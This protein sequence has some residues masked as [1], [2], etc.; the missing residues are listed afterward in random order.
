MVTPDRASITLPA[1]SSVLSGAIL[2]TSSVVRAEYRR[3]ADG[4]HSHRGH[5]TGALCR[6]GD[7]R[8]PEP[9]AWAAP[10][11]SRVHRG[12]GVYP[13]AGGEGVRRRMP[14]RGRLLHRR[15]AA[16]GAIP[17]C[18][19]RFVRGVSHLAG[20]GHDR[21]RRAGRGVSHRRRRQPRPAQGSGPR[22]RGNHHAGGLRAVETVQPQVHHHHAGEL[23]RDRGR[24]C[25]VGGAGVSRSAGART[26]GQAVGRDLPCLSR[27]SAGPAGSVAAPHRRPGGA[28]RVPERARLHGATLHRSRHRPHRGASGRARLEG[29]HRPQRVGHAIRAQRPHRRGVHDAAQPAGRRHGGHHQ[30]AELRRPADRETSA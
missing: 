5:E 3:C 23:V 28:T 2:S 1:M 8:G 16:A 25:A 10:G 22:A 29:R 6:L 18:A 24:G 27:G 11:H 7:R 26:G 19:G 20:Q 4:L 30:A 13:G 21:A 15:R 14:L 17:A 12:G 9:A